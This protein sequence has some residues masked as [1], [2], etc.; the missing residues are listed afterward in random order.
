MNVS[1]KSEHSISLFW[2]LW[3]DRPIRF[4]LN[5]ALLKAMNAA[6]TDHITELYECSFI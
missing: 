2:L 3:G 4:P 5:A 1:I 6:T